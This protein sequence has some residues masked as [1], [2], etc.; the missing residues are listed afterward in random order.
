MFHQ[1]EAWLLSFADTLPLPLFAALASFTEEIIAPIPSGPVMLV[2]GSIAS[3]QGYSLPLL[4]LL[5]LVAAAGKLLGSLVVYFVADK[6]EDVITVRFAKFLGITHAQIES[7]GKRLGNGWK[8]YAVLTLLRSLPFVPS[9]VVS[10]GAGAL[11]VRLRVFIVAT[12]IGSI[13]RDF[14][15]LYFGYI[16]FGAAEELLARFSSW[17]DIFVAVLAA[18]LAALFVYLCIRWFRRRR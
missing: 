16:G 3:I 17:E 14:T 5:A 13:L 4:A 10:F 6:A 18:V 15:F 11:K 8:D 12:V 1:L 2:T 7:F 9:A